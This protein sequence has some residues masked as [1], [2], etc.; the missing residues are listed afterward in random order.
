VG[1][2]VSHPWIPGELSCGAAGG[3]GALAVPPRTSKLRG[4]PGQDGSATERDEFLIAR[5][6]LGHSAA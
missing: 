1:A 3:L 4:V 2:R 6:A 5:R